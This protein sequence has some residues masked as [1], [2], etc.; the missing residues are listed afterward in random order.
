MP[1]RLAPLLVLLAAFTA[2][3]ERYDGPRP[4]KPD[5][6][7]LKH[8]S[9]LIPTEDIVA[10]EQDK[11][12]DEVTYVMDG[13]SSPVVTPLASP[14]FL[15]LADKMIPE[16]LELYKLDVKNGHREV[17]IGK[18]PTAIR[19]DV[20]RYAADKLWKVE[21]DETLEPG[22]Y[23]LSQADDPSNRAFCFQVR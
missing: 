21:V 2:A 7:Y 10:K 4:A 9:S 19:L 6:P 15:V 18:K 14:I 11:K 17:R 20:M 16:K 1:R 23:A 5:L 13:A 22:E 8:A 12:R 3:Q